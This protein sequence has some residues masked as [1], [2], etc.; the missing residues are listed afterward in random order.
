[1][2]NRQLADQ[3]FKQFASKGLGSQAWQ[4]V[5]VANLLSFK[6]DGHF[7]D[8][9]SNDYA[10]QS[11]SYFLE[12]HLNWKGICV[13][14]GPQYAAAYKD[15]SCRF[16][17]ADATQV[18][19]KS[20][21][22]EQGFPARVDYLSLDVD[23][24]S[25]ASLNKLPLDDYRFSVI[26]IEHDS[27]RVGDVLKIEERKVLQAHNYIM[28]VSDIYAPLGCGMGPKLSFEDWW[29]DPIAFNMDKITKILDKNRYPDEYVAQLKRYPDTYY[30]F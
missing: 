10:A 21:L 14:I 19:Y 20:A 29:I 26:T 23:D 17:N 2:D 12:Q 4:D 11:N 30:L 5:F 7:L 8:I 28:L 18:D 1:M 27:Y 16:I 9:G 3:V 13:E 24:S 22:I 15:R 25:L 6:K